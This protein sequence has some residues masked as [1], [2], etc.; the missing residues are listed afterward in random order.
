[1]YVATKKLVEKLDPF[2]A[3][4]TDSCILFAGYYQ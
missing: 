3:M 2:E 1:M 4:A